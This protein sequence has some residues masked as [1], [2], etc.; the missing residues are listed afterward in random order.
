MKLENISCSIASLSCQTFHEN[1]VT[2]Q[3]KWFQRRVSGPDKRARGASSM[4]RSMLLFRYKVLISFAVTAKLI[5]VFVFA[6]AK[7]WFSH[8]AAHSGNRPYLKSAL[9]QMCMILTLIL[10][11]FERK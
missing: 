10:V 2:C 7:C 6:Y 3:K 4:F 8:D 5:C 11:S 1:T 9:F